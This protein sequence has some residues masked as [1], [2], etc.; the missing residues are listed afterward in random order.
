M[1]NVC[2]EKLMIKLGEIYRKL[3]VKVSEIA[4]RAK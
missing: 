3:T 1:Q 2:T 4:D